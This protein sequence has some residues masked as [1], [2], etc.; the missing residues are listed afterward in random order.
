MCVFH[1][2]YCNQSMLFG[3]RGCTG[4]RSHRMRVTHEFLFCFASLKAGIRCC[5]RADSGT[6]G[7]FPVS[8][9]GGSPLKHGAVRNEDAH[10]LDM[11]KSRQEI[12]IIID[13]GGKF[14]PFRAPM[15]KTP[16]WQ[17]HTHA[18]THA[19]LDMDD[20]W[21]GGHSRQEQGLR[22]LKGRP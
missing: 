12:S 21:R 16:S 4:R 7:M 18:C 2:I 1:P 10:F 9:R 5:W 19:W 13:G 14:Q 8:D 3:E 6:F 17:R 15:P 11:K 22:L 20:C